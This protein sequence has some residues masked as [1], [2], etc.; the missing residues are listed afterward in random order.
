MKRLNVCIVHIKMESSANKFAI[1]SL[2]LSFSPPFFIAKCKTISAHNFRCVKFNKRDTFFC[3]VFFPLLAVFLLT[4]FFTMIS[5]VSFYSVCVFDKLNSS[6]H[7]RIFIKDGLGEAVQNSFI[8]DIVSFVLAR[9]K[10]SFIGVN[11]ACV[12]LTCCRIQSPH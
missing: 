5:I 1:F 7:S 3:S 8:W 4:L 2:W 6:I 12:L 11:H 9:T 10:H